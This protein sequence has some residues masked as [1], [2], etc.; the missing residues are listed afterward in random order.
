[1]AEQYKLPKLGE[2]GGKATVAQ[3]LVAVGDAVAPDQSVLE[4]ET[5]KAVV[6]VPFNVAASGTVTEVLVKAGDEVK[7]GS[8]IFAFTAEGAGEKAAPADE[9]AADAKAPAPA[10]AAPP[11]APPAGQSPA[12]SSPTPS[13]APPPNPVPTAPA[14]TAPGEQNG[15][16]A[17]G[18]API[19]PAA[20]GEPIPAAPSVR[21]LAR[22]L[23]VDLRAVAGSGP[24][25]RISAEDVKAHVRAQATPALDGATASSRPV[26]PAEPLPDFSQWGP[27]E[28]VPMSGIRKATARHLSHAWAAPHVTQFD[29]ADITEIE[30]LRKRYGPRAEKAGGKLTLT[31]IL[32]KAAAVALHK[33]PNFNSSIDVAAG[34]LIQKGYVHIGVAVDTENGLLVPV[35]RDVDRKGLIELAVEL[36]EVAEKARAR[37]LTTADM[38]GGCFTI[39]NLGGI[40]GTNFTPVVNAPE[41]AILGVARGRMEP[42]YRDDEFVPR[43]MLPLALSYD[44]RVIDGADGAR[45][46]RFIAESLEDPFLL[47]MGG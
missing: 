8:P 28:R 14:Q 1:M 32:L 29:V 44:H 41:V 39:S 38:Q 40:G 24:H 15:A 34:E 31:A 19:E 33:F 10:A 6:E 36:G 7:E 30:G 26:A 27:V 4:V 9:S 21:R 43:L 2:T 25:G 17:H 37:K 35:L 42:V 5:D 18:P 11:A 13:P 46:L 20:P 45:F 3:V 16:G 22:E 23:G 47:A 12:A